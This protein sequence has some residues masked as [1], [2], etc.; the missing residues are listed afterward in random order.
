MKWVLM[1]KSVDTINRLCNINS[2]IETNNRRINR[3]ANRFKVGES[4]WCPSISGSGKPIEIIEVIGNEIPVLETKYI[5]FQSNMINQKGLYV[6]PLACFK[7]TIENKELLSKLY[8]N[9]HFSFH[10]QEKVWDNL[11]D[12]VYRNILEI[13]ENE[14]VIND[15]H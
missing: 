10:N 7:L 5:G 3:S 8:P 9:F 15:E 6:P 4:V 14:G 1:I 2:L 12:D 11:L 13:Y